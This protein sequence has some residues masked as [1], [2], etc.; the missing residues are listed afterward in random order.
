MPAGRVFLEMD[1]Q[2]GYE[3]YISE[4][5]DPRFNLALEDILF[6]RTENT[7]STIMYLWQNQNT[8]VIGKSQNAWKEVRTGL[9]EAEGGIMVRRTSGG[10]AVFHD[11]GNLCFTCITPRAEYENINWREIIAECVRCFGIDAKVNGRND[12]VTGDGRKFSGNA[13]RFSKK[14]GLIH[15]TLLVDADLDKMGRYLSVSQAKLEAKGVK[16]VRSRV[17]NLKELSPYISIPALSD[18]LIESFSRYASSNGT[19]AAEPVRVSAV[20][21]VIEADGE[22]I[23]LWNTSPEIDTDGSFCT[24]YQKFASWEWRFG[25]TYP[26]NATIERRFDWGTVFVEMFVENGTIKNASVSTDAMEADLGEVL[27]AAIKG[28][29]L[30]E[31]E[32]RHAITA[33]MAL[34]SLSSPSIK[35]PA[36]VISDMTAMIA[37]I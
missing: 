5:N 16:S 1:L 6:E 12:I 13:F 26:F 28:V 22:T 25:E 15:G 8:V 36:Q 14:A 23:P 3:I 21:T 37:G 18:K 35:E 33:S 34:L 27:S 32:L 30:S 2:P 31:N 11:M 29:K 10:G 24:R 19:E 17:V 9:L 20:D 4:A 7:G